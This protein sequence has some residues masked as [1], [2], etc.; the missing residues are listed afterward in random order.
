M[1]SVTPPYIFPLAFLTGILFNLN[2][3]C[4]SATFLWTNTPKQP[5]RMALLAAIR[6]GWGTLSNPLRRIEP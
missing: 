3:S 1:A 5:S 2:P 4:G 6:I